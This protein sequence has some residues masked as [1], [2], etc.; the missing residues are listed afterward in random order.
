MTNLRH[1]PFYLLQVAGPETD[2]ITQISI[3]YGRLGSVHWESFN[4][5][6]RNYNHLGEGFI[7]KVFP[8]SSEFTSVSKYGN[9]RTRTLEIFVK[10]HDQIVLPRIQR[11]RNLMSGNKFLTNTAN[12]ILYYCVHTMVAYWQIKQCTTTFMKCFLL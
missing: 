8:E 7:E 6:V 5:T 3:I 12:Q 9:G 10:K 11:V 4:N 2:S 1:S